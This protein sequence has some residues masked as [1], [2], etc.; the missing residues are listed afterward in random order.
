MYWN[1]PQTLG[2][3]KTIWLNRN[4]GCIE[5]NVKFNKNMKD[6]TL[7]RNIG[8]IEI[9]FNGKLFHVEMSLN[10]NIGC[11]E[12]LKPTEVVTGEVRVEP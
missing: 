1:A 4:I 3:V 5:I 11:I 8:C 12:I 2:T 6:L 7:N 9:W 10:R